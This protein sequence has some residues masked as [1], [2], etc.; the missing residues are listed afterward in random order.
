MLNAKQPVSI[1][2]MPGVKVYRDDRRPERFYAYPLKPRLARDADGSPVISVLFYGKK[3][4]GKVQPTGGMLNLSTSLALSE[5]E[6][7][8]LRERLEA[9]RHEELGL[10]AD[11]PLPAVELV[12]PSWA[13]GTVTVHLGA[14]LELRGTP[15]LMGTNEA[16]L[17]LTLTADQAKQLQGLWK[18]GLPNAKI[19]YDMLSETARSE[20]FEDRSAQSGSASTGRSTSS[21]SYQSELEISRTGAA[22]FA[23]QAEGPLDVSA[24]AL[25]GR[26]NEI[27]L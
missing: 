24:S 27:A 16:A 12:A 23:V 8:R 6:A 10:P 25:R 3:V 14:E 26:A 2:D 13:S 17:S 11:A 18:D 4:G 1:A 22:P 9:L 19:R 5:A 15:S 7:E 20:R 21:Y